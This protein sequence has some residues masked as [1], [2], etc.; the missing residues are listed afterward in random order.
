MIS[1]KDLG[2]KG[3][4]GNILFE[5]AAAIGLA[6]RNNDQYVFPPFKESSFFNLKNCFSDN[7]KYT[8]R[9]EEK[10]FA[11]DEIPYRPD[12]DISGY[13]QSY[14]YWEDCQDLIRYLFTSQTPISAIPNSV[15]IHVRRGDY[16]TLGKCFNILPMSYYEQALSMIKAKR[17]LV[18]SDD[19][20]WCKANFRGSEYT[21]IEGNEPCIDLILMSS[22]ENNIIGNS[23][24]SWWSAWLN[25]NPNKTVIAP[26]NWFG[27]DLSPTHDTKDLFYPTWTVI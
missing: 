11:Y 7:I 16:L 17:V 6:V 9:Y 12:M 8:Y 10:R 18:F 3:R 19:I 4:I 2:H 15:A 13:F 20:K 26:K 24:F 14:K 27:A 5:G 21:F 22:V 25:K 23:S 1:F